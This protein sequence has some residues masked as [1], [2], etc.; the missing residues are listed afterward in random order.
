M[1]FGQTKC[2]TCNTFVENDQ[3]QACQTGT[4]EKPLIG[5]TAC[6]NNCDICKD[7]IS[8]LTCSNGFELTEN[9]RQTCQAIDKGTLT[10]IA[11]DD[12]DS[13][14]M[15]VWMMI[16]I[17]LVIF[18]LVIVVIA[19]FILGCVVYKKRPDP[20]DDSKKHA[21]VI[22]MESNRDDDELI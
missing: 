12:E 16:T 21:K 6:I 20:S 2:V 19:V 4:F 11:V 7:T 22:N 3:C 17:S 13:E 18:I 9:E 15:E 1:I 8:C 10:T 14:T 5:C